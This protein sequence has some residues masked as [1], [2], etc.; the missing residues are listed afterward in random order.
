MV[1]FHAGMTSHQVSVGLCRSLFETGAKAGQSSDGRIG[2][3]CPATLSV[4]VRCQYMTSGSECLTV[5]NL[6]VLLAYY[7]YFGF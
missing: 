4:P 2:A 7:I 3:K 1:F 5:L 6:I